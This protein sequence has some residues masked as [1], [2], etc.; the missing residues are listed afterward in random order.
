[1]LTS[2]LVP[3]DDAVAAVTVTPVANADRSDAT[4]V[5]NEA[6]EGHRENDN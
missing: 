3:F 5:F 4:A 2:E 6:I 1:M